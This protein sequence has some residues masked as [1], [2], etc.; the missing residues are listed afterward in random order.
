MQQEHTISSGR[1]TAT[2][3]GASARCLAF[4]GVEIL[5]GLSAPVRDEGW[6]TFDTLIENADLRPDGFRCVFSHPNGLFRGEFEFGL[7]SERR[8]VANF[9]LTFARDAQINRAG[10]CLLHPLAGVRGTA[11]TVLHADGTEEECCFP[12][13]IS[14]D[15]PAKNIV[16]LTHRIGRITLRFAMEGEVFEMEDQRNWSDAS[17]KTYCRPLAQPRPFRVNAG[18]TLRQ[19][20][21]I[22]IIAIDR[23]SAPETIR[24]GQHARLPAITLAFDPALCAAEALEMFP[25]TPVLARVDREMPDDIL[26]RLARRDEIA[27]EIV[28]DALDEIDE[29]AARCRD[30]GL[31]PLRVVALPRP[32]LQSH[33]PGGPWPTGPRPMDAI[34]VVR[35]TFPGVPTGGGSL[36]HFTEFNRCRPGTEV[37]YLTFGNSA[38]VHAADDLSV[39]QTLEALPDIFATAQHVQRDK[40]L[41]LGLFS[42][43]MRSNPYGPDP[44]ADWKDKPTPMARRDQRQETAFAAAYAIAVLVQA[45]RAG[46][47][48]IALAMPDGDLGSHGRPL[49]TVIEA[50]SGRA[51]SDV[52]TEVSDDHL[53]RLRAAD[54]HALA[55]FAP[56]PVEGI[57]SGGFRIEGCA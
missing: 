3:A 25:R 8:C 50:L 39:V 5:R 13:F 46:V 27:L 33:Q 32:Y 18:E 11:M 6:G 23:A 31:T 2:V 53:Y 34:P 9:T 51:G 43:G 10:F 22:D 56:V 49:G 20:I 7:P 40:P 48:S 47:S 41:H 55:N 28:F 19:R 42:I 57:A 12:E 30:A 44:Q 15:Q 14:P 4:D 35:R 16:A 45:T 37:D 21:T 36:T 54:L 52:V 38:I 1:L 26:N 29:M 17:F 24:G